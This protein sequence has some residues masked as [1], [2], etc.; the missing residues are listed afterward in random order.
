[1]LTRHGSYALP[2]TDRD[3]K[4]AQMRTCA[5]ASQSPPTP[6]L[7]ERSYLTEEQMRRWSG[8]PIAC[9]DANPDIV[10][11]CNELNTPTVCMLDRGRGMFEMERDV[12]EL[13]P[14]AT[15]L[16]VPEAFTG[17]KRLR[18]TPGRRIVITMQAQFLA[19][20]KLLNDEL[21]DGRYRFNPEFYDAE[22]AGLLRVMVSEVAQGCPNGR[23][24][25]ESLSLG[26]LLHL[27]R[28]RV[29][30]PRVRLERGRLSA[31]Q[32]RRLDELIDVELSN[33]ISLD[34]L[35][36]AVGFS[37]AHFTRLFKSTM[38]VSPYRYVLSKRVDAASN[39]V[40]HS[41][42]SL[43]EIAAQSGF[44]SQS[45][46][47]DAFSRVLGMPPG[48]LRRSERTWAS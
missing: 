20:H 4:N 36:N 11:S 31:A 6:A 30:R 14:G 37:K 22:L 39:L 47:T 17:K 25:A 48:A 13:K 8:I 19:S 23:L 46:M 3:G 16:F 7:A 10:L 18:C 38:G 21:V 28:T 26:V 32:I 2:T 5:T 15:G 12:L 41:T 27:A 1:M 24:L 42:E 40:K 35:A 43:A 33:E 34:M 44:A 29:E 45:H 9:F